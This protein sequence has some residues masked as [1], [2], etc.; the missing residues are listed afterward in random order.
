MGTV[1]PQ[2]RQILSTGAINV[3]HMSALRHGRSVKVI[4]I[5]MIMS[6]AFITICPSWSALCLMLIAMLLCVTNFVCLRVTTL[7]QMTPSHFSNCFSISLVNL[8]P[9]FSPTTQYFAVLDETLELT[10]D[11]VDPESM[12]I[13]FSLM[14]GSPSK[15]VVRGDVLIW[16]VTNDAKTQFFL[17]AT[18]ACQA[19]SYVNITVSLDVCQCQNNGRC[20]P[21][22]NNPRGSGFYECQCVPGYTGDKCETNIDDCRS[23]PCVRGNNDTIVV[24]PLAFARET[25]YAWVILRLSFTSSVAKCHSLFCYS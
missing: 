22:P 12:P 21:H 23:Y 10:I 11:A 15:A 9:Q 6:S 8:P 19:T 1:S 18:D 3:Y 20:V 13:T 17:K 16:N 7:H 2:T 25:F 4:I 14:D 24:T 5:I